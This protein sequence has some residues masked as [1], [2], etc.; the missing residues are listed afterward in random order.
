MDKK[1]K[2]QLYKHEARKLEL[3]IKCDDYKAE[4]KRIEEHIKQQEQLISE[5]KEE[6]GE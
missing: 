6:L 4:I 2:A 1:K 3:E 5:L